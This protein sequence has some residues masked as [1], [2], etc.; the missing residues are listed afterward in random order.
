MRYASVTSLRCP[1]EAGMAMVLPEHIPHT[2][3]LSRY[4][5]GTPC[6]GIQ[7][8]YLTL[9]EAGTPMA[10]PAWGCRVGTYN[11]SHCQ[12]PVR[13]WYAPLGD[14]KRIPDT[15]KSRY[16][17]GTPRYG[18]RTYTSHCQKP[19]RLWY[20]LLADTKRI[21]D[22]ARSRYARGTPRSGIQ[23]TYLTLPEAGTPAVRPAWGYKAHT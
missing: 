5:H 8:Q 6:L 11:N 4:A 20:A 23:S 3:R 10:R 21:P 1:S 17:R 16:A 22:T 19:V 15:A 13:P 12:K 9:P 2:A 7:S 14:T 18:C